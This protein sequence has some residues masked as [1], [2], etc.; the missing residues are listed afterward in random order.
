MT[1]AFGGLT[2]P[3][4]AYLLTAGGTAVAGEGQ[5]T[6]VA[7]AFT[8]PFNDGFLPSIYSGGSIVIGTN[9]D[10]VAPQGDTS[11]YLNDGSTYGSPTTI[12]FGNPL[13]YFGF[14]YGSVDAYNTVQLF[15]DNTLLAT[16]SGTDLGN[17]VD[18]SLRGGLYVNIFTSGAAENFNRVVFS[19]P[20]NA[21]ESDNHAW[22]IATPSTLPTTPVP[23][24]STYALLTA[25]LLLIGGISRRRMQ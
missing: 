10:S 4:H 19:S 6:S 5:Y 25:G 24:P 18:P 11:F 1:S 17:L 23:E 20:A 22:V 9:A 15:S 13:S 2:S 7:G 21:F 16:Y 14:Y 8:V 12:N 3:A